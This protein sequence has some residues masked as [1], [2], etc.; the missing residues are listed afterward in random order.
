MER[1]HDRRGTEMKD[2]KPSLESR[3]EKATITIDR[4][5]HRHY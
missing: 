1:D 2:A 5:N 3:G 4:S